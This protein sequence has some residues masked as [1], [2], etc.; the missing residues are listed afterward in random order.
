MPAK[1]SKACDVG[2]GFGAKGSGTDA[3]APAGVGAAELVGTAREWLL[4]AQLATGG[5]KSEP[6]L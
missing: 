1:G 3:N 2:G 6:R 5:E 4:A